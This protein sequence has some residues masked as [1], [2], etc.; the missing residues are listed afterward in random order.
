MN[1]T[2][3]L[4]EAGRL[5]REP[6][7]RHPVL[8]IESD[9][10]GPGPPQDAGTLESIAAELEQHRDARGRC[11]VMTLGILLAVPDTKRMRD[12]QA[13]DYARASLSAPQ[14][15]PILAA[16]RRGTAAGVFSPQ[17][18][19][20]E[21]YWP[22]ALI[23]ASRRV[24]A[25]REWLMQDAVPRHEDLP[26]ELQ[27]RWIDGANLPGRSLPLKAVKEAA[28]AE[29]S[30]FRELFGAAPTVAVPPTFVWSEPVEAAWCAAGVSVIVTPGRR[31]CGR[32]RDGK[33]VADTGRLHNGQ[34]SGSGAMY[35]VR[36]DYFEP[37]LGH[38]A[39]HGLRALA[40]KTALG[41]P[42][43]LEMHRFNFTRLATDREAALRE[44]ASLLAAARERYPNLR[45]MS[46]AELAAA[47]RRGDPELVET[48]FFVRLRGWW[49]RA[50]GS[51]TSKWTR[52]AFQ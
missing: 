45:F 41:R 6:V 4:R 27:S 28:T 33:L 47:I 19:G 3:R 25:V 42:A 35:V 8:I 9:D 16:I 48:R 26:S 21:H 15:E 31:Y 37:A 7:L 32:N 38:R 34:T 2:E 50:L 49:R 20:M 10:W 12:E 24:P 29:A 14:F 39:A 44:L 1:W 36:D 13:R 46:T 30:A 40:E 51:R 17:L 23:E 5:W 52:L 11:A 18:H 43:L 22:D